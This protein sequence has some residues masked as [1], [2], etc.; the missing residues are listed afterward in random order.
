MACL[1]AVGF[2]VFKPRGTHQRFLSSSGVASPGNQFG[3]LGGWVPVLMK[4]DCST[5]IPSISSATVRTG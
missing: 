4:R 5:P 3:S 2:S 1:W